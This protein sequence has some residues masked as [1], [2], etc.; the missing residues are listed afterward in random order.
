MAVLA[1]AVAEEQA[2]RA[3]LVA[4]VR[5]VELA[6]LAALVAEKGVAPEELAARA[7]QGA[8]VER[9]AEQAKTQIIHHRDVDETELAVK[10]ALVD[11]MVNPARKA[12]TAPAAK[13]DAVGVAAV[14]G[15]AAGSVS[16]AARPRTCSIASRSIVSIATPAT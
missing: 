7:G 10:M 12:L 6:A 4:P 5:R 8:P 15:S 9:G 11:K 1:A 13:A 3:E 14:A 2:A 16:A